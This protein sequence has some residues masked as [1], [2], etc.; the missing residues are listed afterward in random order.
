MSTLLRSP[1]GDSFVTL[2]T[3]MLEGSALTLGLP[4]PAA[5][6]FSEAARSRMSWGRSG[7]PPVRKVP[8]GAAG[9]RA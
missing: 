6:A 4:E 2:V 9:T 7:S 5:D 8:A 1:E 3:T